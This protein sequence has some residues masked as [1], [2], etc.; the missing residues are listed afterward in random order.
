MHILKGFLCVC[1]EDR[2]YRIQGREERDQLRIKS[3]TEMDSGM[4]GGHRE[5]VR[6]LKVDKYLLIDRM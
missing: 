6:R 3:R 1:V 4:G 5:M 2:L